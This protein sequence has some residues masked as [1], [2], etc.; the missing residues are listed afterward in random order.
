M[1]VGLLYIKLNKFNKD[2]R[3]CGFFAPLLKAYR[4]RLIKKNYH[5]PALVL[6]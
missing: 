2:V 3:A 6:P 4:I 1:K 5:E